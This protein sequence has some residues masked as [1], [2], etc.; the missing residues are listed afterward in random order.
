MKPKRTWILIAD[1]GRA[2]VLG[3]LSKAITPEMRKVVLA[4]AAKDLT[5]VLR[6]PATCNA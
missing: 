1:G 5:K 6:S 4:E 2:R 3:D